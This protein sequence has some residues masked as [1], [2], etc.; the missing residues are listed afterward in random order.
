MRI[1]VGPVDDG[2]NLWLI[3]P[4]PCSGVFETATAD[5]SDLQ[6][7]VTRDRAMDAAIVSAL[8]AGRS[9][10]ILEREHL[11]LAR[12]RRIEARMIEI[13]FP[14]EWRVVERMGDGA[15]SIDDDR[16]AIRWFLAAGSSF[17]VVGSVSFEKRWI[18][19]GVTIS[20]GRAK[21]LG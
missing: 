5:A 17:L 20:G 11:F 13:G 12:K 9:I 21:A 19:R 8:C 4:Q 16:G 18:P 3:E 10:A 1:S 15:A 2:K 7:H 14:P 6:L